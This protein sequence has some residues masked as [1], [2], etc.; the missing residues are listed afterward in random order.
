VKPEQ[1]A[2]SPRAVVAELTGLLAAG[3]IANLESDTPIG[4]G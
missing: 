1:V 2:G 3:A 4:V